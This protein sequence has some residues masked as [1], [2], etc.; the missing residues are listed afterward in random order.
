MSQTSPFLHFKLT[1]ACLFVLLFFHPLGCVLCVRK[2][3]CNTPGRR[4]EKPQDNSD[5]H[6][7]GRPARG[8]GTHL[9]L[10]P[11]SPTMLEIHLSPIS[12]PGKPTSSSWFHSIQL[13]IDICIYIR[14]PTIVKSDLKASLLIATTPRCRGGHDSFPWLVLH[15]LDPY[16]IML[17]EVPVV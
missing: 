9:I 12:F 3:M 11:S 17:K 4:W 7:W 13:Y 8:I 15:T 14:W 2:E 10:G 5:G 16:L 1:Q 6:E